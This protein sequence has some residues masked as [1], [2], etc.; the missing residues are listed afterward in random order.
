MKERSESF[1][2]YE[3]DALHSVKNI[4]QCDLDITGMDWNSS[5]SLLGISFGKENDVGGLKKLVL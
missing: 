5:S 3:V 4:G 2:E 1:F